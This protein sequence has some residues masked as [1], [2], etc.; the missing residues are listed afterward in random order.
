MVWLMQW[1]WLFFTKPTWLLR[2]G[3]LTRLSVRELA[4]AELERL[5]TQDLEGRALVFGKACL[6][7]FHW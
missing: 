4:L 7:M 1:L 5:Q 3:F 2:T 6:L